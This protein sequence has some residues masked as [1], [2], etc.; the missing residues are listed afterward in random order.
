MSLVEMVLGITIAG[1]VLGAI[2]MS[3]IVILRAEKPTAS[4]ITEA[5]DVAFLQTYLPVDYSAVVSRSTEPTDQPIAGKTLPGTNVLS[6]IR[7]VYGPSGTTTMTVSYRYVNV[8]A[9]WQLIRYEW[10]N[11]SRP[12]VLGDTIVGHELAAPPPGWTANQAPAHAVAITAQASADGLLGDDMQVVFASGNVFTTSGTALAA[13]GSLP[14]DYSGGGNDPVALR[15]RCGGRVT[16]VLD[17]SGSIKFVGAGPAQ[18]RDA[19]KGFIDAFTGTPTDMS[20]TQ[21]S[22]TASTIYPSTFGTYFSVLTAGNSAITS[23][24]SGIDAMA[25]SGNTNWEDGLYRAARDNSGNPLAVQPE[26][27]VFVTDGDPT[28]IRP[29]SSANATTATAKAVDAANFARAHGA[30][31]IGIIV[32]AGANSSASIGR[33]KQVVGATQWDGSVNGSGQVVVGNAA[34]ADFF[35]APGGNFSRL[36]EVLRAVVAGECGGTVTVQKRIEVGAVLEDPTQ[37]WTYTTETGSRTL[38]P[39]EEAAITFDFSFP[40]GVGEKAVQITETPSA[41]FS[42]HRVECTSGGATLPANRISPAPNGQ[43]GVVVTITPNEAVSCTFIGRP[44]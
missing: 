13:G 6:L 8:A 38:D 5:T 34:T 42:Y 12:G 43:P 1:F 36:G 30:R 44:A 24:K 7:H 29:S 23:A 37:T 18:V 21:F 19:A 4:R 39:D 16:L 17:N 10:G 14:S 28:Y 20:V 22:T 11:P 35:V 32:G 27:L 33:L 31:V 3:M 41:G 9:D 26:L 2:S 25:F 15:S 40:T